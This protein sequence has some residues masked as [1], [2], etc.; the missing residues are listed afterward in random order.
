[1]FDMLL[2]YSSNF[3]YHFQLLA[4]TGINMIALYTLF[5]LNITFSLFSPFLY[6]HLSG[7]I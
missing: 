4:V 5:A 1:M 2:L 6:H 7:N 3:R